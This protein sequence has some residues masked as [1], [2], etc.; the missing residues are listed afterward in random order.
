[1]T[2]AQGREAQPVPGAPV[3]EAEPAL[4]T[5]QLGKP[6]AVRQDRIGC[7]RTGPGQLVGGGKETWKSFMGA[8]ALEL[9]LERMAGMTCRAGGLGTYS[10]GPHIQNYS[11]SR[12]QRKEA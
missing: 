4:K 2:E 3:S 11:P 12:T 10:R 6:E 1:M 7:Q 9:C 8:T 5:P